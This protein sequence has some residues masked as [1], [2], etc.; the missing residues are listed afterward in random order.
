MQSP[1]EDV[2]IFWDYE[3]CHASA[4]TS[5]YEVAAGIRKCAHRFG[6]VKHF[7]AYMETPDC[8]T[9]RSLS[10]R[11]ELQSSGVSLTD[12][13]HNGRKNV[14]D[15]MIMVDMLAYALDHG[16]PATLILISGDRDFAYAVSIL[17]L[18]RYCVVVISL[19]M[20]GAHISLKSQAS[21]CLDWNVDVMGY[22]NNSPSNLEGVTGPTTAVRNPSSSIQSPIAHRS[23]FLSS[24]PESPYSGFRVS[25]PTIKPVAVPA[26]VASSGP[27][28]STPPGTAFN[29][30]SAIDHPP[31]E[32]EEPGVICVPAP[33]YSPNF[34]PIPTAP[35]LGSVAADTVPPAV[36]DSTTPIPQSSARESWPTPVVSPSALFSRDLVTA[37]IQRCMDMVAEVQPSVSQISIP[38]AHV[39][40]TPAI[41]T[42]HV[43]VA[44][45]EPN[46]AVSTEV[47]PFL[48]TVPPLFESLV[49]ILKDQRAKGILRP[50]RSTISIQIIER[51]NTLYKRAGV[52]KFS[53]FTALAEQAK[54]IELGGRDGQAWILLRPDWC[55]AKRNTDGVVTPVASA[56]NSAPPCC[57]PAV[58]SGQIPVV[59]PTLLSFGDPIS[60]HI[61]RCT[62]EAVPGRSSENP[63]LPSLKPDAPAA[64]PTPPPSALGAA[65][66]SGSTPSPKKIP[67]AFKPLVE[68]LQKH[69]AKGV[70]RPLRSTVG[71]DVVGM[72]RTVYKEAGVNNFGQLAAL[73]EKAKVV[74]LGGSN[75]KEWIS[76]HPDWSSRK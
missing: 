43:L 31:A 41:L 57:S 38:P 14:A 3:N 42:P 22:S 15:Q 20:P 59:S 46:N 47:Q 8:D 5:G 45:V 26:S 12:C 64:A 40:S 2:A 23:S 48:K 30:E 17:R 73:A 53:Q 68:A 10:L 28:T 69:K 9:A 39:P 62:N 19:P 52:A 61:H 16:P 67:P 11:S 37:H 18:R 25:Q 49:E 34:D 75:G 35:S 74:Q 71:F 56:S 50:L 72:A 33:A 60:D 55:T 27:S 66:A 51:D 44:D 76:L 13:P 65:H 29:K 58:E 24:S 6:A 4:Q 32:P 63:S 1:I 54:I 7:K 36:S 70:A 21:V